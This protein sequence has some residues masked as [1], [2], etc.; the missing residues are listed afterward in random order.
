VHCYRVK[1]FNA[2]I[3]FIFTILGGTASLTGKHLT[4]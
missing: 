4:D 2:N 3:Q 1:L